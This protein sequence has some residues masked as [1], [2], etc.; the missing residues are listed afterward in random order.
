MGRIKS[1]MIKKAARQLIVD[2]DHPFAVGFEHNKK[3]LGNSTMPSK[4]VRNKVAGYITRMLVIKKKGP[5]PKKAPKPD[6]FGDRDRDRPRREF[7][8]DY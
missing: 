3:A 2:E 5:R 6:E 8:R 7:R 4:S 1:L